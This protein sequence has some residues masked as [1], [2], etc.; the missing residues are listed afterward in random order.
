MIVIVIV[1]VVAHW[2]AVGVK[3][4]AVVA[5]L[6]IVGDQVPVTPLFEV[7]DKADKIA[8][9]QIGATWLNV[10]VIAGFTITFLQSVAQVPV[11]PP[12]PVGVMNKA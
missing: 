5:V 7:V 1:A 2:P 3:V 9:E 12:A 8:P 10:G 11:Q 4:Y 6:F